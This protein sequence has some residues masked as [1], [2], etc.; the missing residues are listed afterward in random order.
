MFGCLIVCNRGATFV[1]RRAPIGGALFG[2][3]GGSCHLI[4]VVTLMS[5]TSITRVIAL[6]TRMTCVSRMTRIA[7]MT[8]MTRMTPRTLTI[9]WHPGNAM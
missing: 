6:M 2:C 4:T 5:V 7:H 1:A 8:C 9:F 3:Y